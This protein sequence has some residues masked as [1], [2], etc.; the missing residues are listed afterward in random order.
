MKEEKNVSHIY[1]HIISNSNT[2]FKWKNQKNNILIFIWHRRLRTL[3]IEI[4]VIIFIIRRLF[5]T[6]NINE[7]I[8]PNKYDVNL[9][10]AY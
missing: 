6:F 10:S 5:D 3:S 8:Q 1:A 9:F 4:D 2:I 7:Q